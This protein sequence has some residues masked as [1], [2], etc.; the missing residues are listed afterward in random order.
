MT[1]AVQPLQ[2]SVTPEGIKYSY[3]GSRVSGTVPNFFSTLR[4]SLKEVAP[5]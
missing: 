1:S 2:H 5:F 4:S 3:G